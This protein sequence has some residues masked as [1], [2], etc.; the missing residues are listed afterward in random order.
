MDDG[1][2]KVAMIGT[3]DGGLK[4]GTAVT[5][6]DQPNIAYQVIGPIRAIAI[7]AIKTYLTIFVALIGAGFTTTVLPWHTF[8]E[9][10][11]VSGKLALSGALLGLVKDLLTVFTDLEKRFPLLLGNI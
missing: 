7:R 3:G 5:S 4:S 9:L 1:M 8:A 10:A 2:V 6:G 11:T